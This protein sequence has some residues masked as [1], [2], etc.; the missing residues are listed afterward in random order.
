MIRLTALLA[1]VFLFSMCTPEPENFTVSGNIKMGNG[2]KLYLNELKTNNII[3]VDSTILDDEGNFSFSGISNIPSFFALK[4]GNNYLTL[5]LKN[6]DRVIVTANMEDF[7]ASAE[8][9]GSP[10]SQRAL[11]LRKKLEYNIQR[12]DSMGTYYKSILGTREI[13]K[14][15]DSLNKLSEQIIT[16]H[17]NETK[18]FIEEN[19]AS[20]ASLMALYQ[21][22]APRRYVLNPEEHFEYFSM[23]DSALYNILP[24]SEAVINLHSQILEIKRQKAQSENIES[25]VGI[26]IKAPEIILPN[27]FG[28]TVKLSDLKGKYV[29]IDFWASWCK[30]CRLENPIL[31]KNYTKYHEKGFEIFQ[32]SLD[33]KEEAWLDA[34]EKDNLT[35]IHVSDL[36]FWNSEAAVLYHVQSIPANFLIDKKGVI[37]AKN[38]RGD[39]L[40][41]KLSELFD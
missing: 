16:H 28:D 2:A 37:I 33:K 25:K 8:I 10:E 24:E 3:K 11:G 30:P 38:L 35:W 40:E 13:N 21:Q 39:A 20:L 12:L 26:G 6:N 4:S 22:I 1:I 36:K 23:V 14:V 18:A 34:I 9:E 19:P 41:A 29:L 27:Q 15:R 32:V 7:A 31:V 5:I 17:T